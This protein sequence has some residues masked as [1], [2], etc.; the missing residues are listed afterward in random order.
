MQPGESSSDTGAAAVGWS[1][2]EV[3]GI[4]CGWGRSWKYEQMVLHSMGVGGSLGGCG[5]GWACACR[6][7]V[8]VGGSA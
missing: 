5:C 6:L 4:M 8:W 1:V 3:G 7:E 2:V